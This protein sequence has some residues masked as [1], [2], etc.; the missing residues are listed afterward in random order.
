M[1]RYDGARVTLKRKTGTKLGAAALAIAS[2]LAA[3]SIGSRAPAQ[4]VDDPAE[5]PSMGLN[6]PN[7][8]TFLA[9]TDPTVHKATAIVNG[10]IITDT[11]VDQRL[12]LVLAANGGRIAADER[13]RLKLQVLRNLIDETLEIQEAAANKI[14]VSKAE[15]DQTYARVA[16]N[17]KRTPTTFAS[18]LIE[19][20]SSERSIKRQI[21]GE[22][23]WRRVLSRKVEPFINV[24][25]EEVNAV[26]A[27]LNASKGQQE[28]RIGE[29]FLSST[30]ETSATTRANADRII[31][32][33]RGGGSFVAY[34]RQFSEAS[35]AAVGGD[36]GWV[37]AEQLPEQLAAVAQTLPTGQVSD[38]IAIPGGYSIIAVIDKRQ[39]LTAD[40]RDA[41]LALKQIALTFPKGTTEAQAGPKVESFANAMKTIGGCGKAEETARTLGGEVVDNDQVRIR[42]LPQQLQDLMVNLQIGQA[43]PPFGSLDDG[44]R[45]LVLCGRDDPKDAGA[46][47]REAI[48]SQMEEERVNRRA[49]RYLRDLRRDAVVDYR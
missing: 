28:Y 43:T 45:S 29:I 40:P 32:Q 12:A 9:P 49:R 42:D 16:N 18:Y 48:Q 14:E 11:D 23:A 7:D 36:L 1:A 34:A 46:P 19:Q 5:P 35:T 25:D 3:A 47:S 15:I 8:L 31:Q 10:T 44:V 20:G 37:R 22:L 27:R 4:A 24:G 30:P 17:F 33:V 26:M 39:V 38:A 41:V 21:E 6:L 2:M 13:D